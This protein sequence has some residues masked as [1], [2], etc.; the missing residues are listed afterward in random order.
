MSAQIEGFDHC[1]THGDVESA[2]PAEYA[3]LG[4]A[5]GENPDQVV[6]LVE[7]LG[8]VG[9]VATLTFNAA[10]PCKQLIGKVG[11]N[12]QGGFAVA[13][14][15]SDDQVVGILGVPADGPLG[16]AF[17]YQLGVREFGD[18][19]LRLQRLRTFEHH[20]VPRQ[21]VD[22]A[23]EDHRHSYPFGSGLRGGCRFRGG[24]CSGSGLVF[25]ASRGN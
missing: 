8:V 15:V 22:L 2:G 17:R 25:G 1:V 5:P 11:R 13:E 6:G 16:I 3:A 7:R 24:S 10:G 19:P 20:L 21:I 9:Q 18:E 14:R 4:Y 23:R 12:G